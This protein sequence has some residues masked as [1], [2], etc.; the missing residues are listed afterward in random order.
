MKLSFLWEKT[1]EKF[2]G[3]DI[4]FIEDSGKEY[5]LYSSYE[6]SYGDDPPFTQEYLEKMILKYGKWCEDRGLKILN[7]EIN[8]AALAA[9]EQRD[10]QN[11]KY[12]FLDLKVGL[13]NQKGTSKRK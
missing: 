13:Q 2:H 8:K 5:Q 3:L 12:N 4:S 10:N 6:D 9:A 7:N 11:L 1:D